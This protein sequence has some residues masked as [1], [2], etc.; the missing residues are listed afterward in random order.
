M[1]RQGLG[2]AMIRSHAVLNRFAAAGLLLAG[3][4]M[5]GSAAADGIVAKVVNSPLNRGRAGQGRLCGAEHLSAAP[6]RARHR[7]L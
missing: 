7:F 6:R 4:S 2:C 1:K 5:A 3:L